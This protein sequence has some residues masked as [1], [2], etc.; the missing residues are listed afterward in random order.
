[1]KKSARKGIIK[2]FP[3]RESLISGIPAGDGKTAKLFLQCRVTK[4]I[5]LRKWREAGGFCA[6][7][8]QLGASCFSPFSHYNIIWR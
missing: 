6:A 4:K 5:D 7:R 1:V 8:R 2:L 3:A